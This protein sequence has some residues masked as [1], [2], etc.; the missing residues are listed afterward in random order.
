MAHERTVIDFDPHSADYARDPIGTL[1]RIRGQCP[2]AYSEAH[3]GFWL[4]TRYEDVTRVAFDNQRFSS[5]H[6]IPNDGKSF[7]GVIL[8][9][10]PTS[11]RPI[12][13]DPPEWTHYRRLLNPPFSPQAIE[14]LR[15]KVEEYTTWCLDRR[16]EAGEID[17]VLDLTN[18]LPAMATLHFLGLPV[19]EWESYAVPYHNMVACPPGSEEWNAAGLGVMGCIGKVVEAIAARRQEPR[20]DLL[21]MLTTAEVDGQP[22]DNDLVIETV[23][24]LLAAGLD[25]T[26]GALTNALYYLGEHPDVRHQLQKDAGLIPGYI[27][28]ALRYFSPT[29]ALARTATEDVEI[30]GQLIKAGERVLVCW[31]AANHDPEQFPDPD[32]VV[33]DRTPNRHT[34]FGW[35]PHRCLG[36]PF[37]RLLMTV[38]LEQVLERMPD[39]VPGPDIRRYDTIGTVNGW[40]GCPATFTPGPRRGAA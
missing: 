24:A 25:T 23:S 2:V 38:A 36:A 6:D 40:A 11:F 33:I 17:F 26:T 29:Q 14:A 7:T 35:G 31:A 3:D 28:E 13:M 27:E 19:E 37:A 30:G 15:P 32:E 20:D 8:P 18:P 22:I 9:P 12:E 5:R 21:T 10:P 16:I 39:Y 4:V 1:H 34:S